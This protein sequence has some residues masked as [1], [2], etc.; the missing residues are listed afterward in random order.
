M[1]R[2]CSA[3]WCEPRCPAC[4][5]RYGAA[6]LDERRMHRVKREPFL[7]CDV[8]GLEG[9]RFDGALPGRVGDLVKAIFNLGPTTA[10]AAPMCPG[11][12][13]TDGL[14]PSL[15]TDLPR[16]AG[17]DELRAEQSGARWRNALLSALMLALVLG[18]VVLVA[19][20]TWSLV[21]DQ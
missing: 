11:C 20:R 14:E 12:E 9:P 7:R 19:W 4:R 6:E 17:W 8:C 2:A 3:R 21:Q 13:R 1:C 10:L 5:P 18:G 16:P 15:A